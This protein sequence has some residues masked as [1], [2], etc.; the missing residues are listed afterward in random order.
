MAQVL[1]HVSALAALEEAGLKCGRADFKWRTDDVM[2]YF[3][4][5]AHERCLPVPVMSLQVSPVLIHL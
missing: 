5:M 3:D 2:I 4:F 1:A